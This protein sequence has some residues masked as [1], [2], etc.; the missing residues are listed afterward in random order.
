MS[1]ISNSFDISLSIENKSEESNYQN[2]NSEDYNSDSEDSSKN[3]YKTCSICYDTMYDI[4]VLRCN[5]VL[6]LT[7]FLKWTKENKSCPFCRNQM[8]D[9]DYPEEIVNEMVKEDLSQAKKE[10][11]IIKE[12]FKIN[13]PQENPPIN[14]T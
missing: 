9:L 4:C 8:D 10:V 3:E 12:G 6:C 11:L 1:N 7:C 13:S 2:I 14:I 5:H